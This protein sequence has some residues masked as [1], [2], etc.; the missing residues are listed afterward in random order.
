[1]KAVRAQPSG[2][3][4]L[5][6]ALGLLMVA[7]VAT[8]QPPS[9]SPFHAFLGSCWRAQ[10]SAKVQD[11][12]CFEAMYGG[13]HVRDRHEMREGAKTTYA[14]ETIYSAD[15]PDLIFTYVNSLGGVGQGKVGSADR[16]LG[17]S[18][19]MRASPDKPEQPIDSEW[20]LIDAR[21]YEVR[22]LVKSPDGR[23]RPALIF[24]R[25]TPKRR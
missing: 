3:V 11:T 5:M 16:L 8:A 23:P 9:L 14:G 6:T 2:Y 19:T 20:R 18:G 1:M 15:G 13:A 17:F 25:M 22:S 4:V 10:I 21:H 7:Q 12:H 24:T